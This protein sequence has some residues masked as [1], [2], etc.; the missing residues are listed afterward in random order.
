MP[1]RAYESAN[2]EE[3]LVALFKHL[4]A[5]LPPNTAVLDL[6]RG[7]QKDDGVVAVLTPTNPAAASVVAHAVNGF[8]IVDFSF[9]EYPPTWELPFE[10]RNTKANKNELLQEVEEMCQAVIAGNCE[11][12]R[13]LLSIRGSIQVG[14]WPY[15][16]TNLLVF[17]AVPPLRGT[18]KYEP[19]IATK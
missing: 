5:D 12:K 16:V 13:G 17:R 6:R 8:G 10:G 19:Y 1:L 15:R 3:E 11:H 9:G 2:L 14:S 4:I 18:R 7:P